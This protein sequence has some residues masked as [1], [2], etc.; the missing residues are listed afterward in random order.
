MA[1]RANNN[2]VS[3]S[4]GLNMLV[5][6]TRR[7]KPRFVSQSKKSSLTTA[8]SVLLQLLSSFLLPLLPPRTSPTF[9]LFSVSFGSKETDA[10]VRCRRRR[11]RTEQVEDDEDRKT[12]AR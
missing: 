1:D 12:Q 8:E 3:V 6:T 9:I 5:K 10:N 4:V 7:R 2:N 11:T